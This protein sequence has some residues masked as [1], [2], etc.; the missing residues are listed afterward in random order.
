MINK[1]YEKLKNI[2]KNNYKYIIVLLLIITIFYVKFP[3]YVY[4]GGGTIDLNKRITMNDANSYNG[5]LNM[6]Y[7]SILNGTLFFGALSYIVPDWDVVAKSEVSYEGE[8]SKI[9]EKRDKIYFEEA[10]SN[11]TILAY[12]KAG[13]EYKINDTHNIATYIY[14]EAKTNLKL[15]DEIE[16][17]N[18]KEFTTLLDFKKDIESYNYGDKLSL[19]TNNGNRY[20]DVLNIDDNKKIGVS[21]ITTYDVETKNNLKIISK[22]NEYGS[23]GGLM[24][25]LAIYNKLIKEDITKGLNIVGTGTIDTDGNVGE[26]AGVKYKLMGANDIDADVFLVPH[27]NYKEA[28]EFIKKKDYNIKL[29]EVNSFDEAIQA[30]KEL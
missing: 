26:I 14:E 25:S 15:F 11:A 2:I 18:D 24:L 20:A 5:K 9:S 8:N 7:V 23:S 13:F 16:S 28:L 3:F 30:L 22:N 27:D 19:G 12:K 1:I 29:I 10:V 17:V 21:I 6:A 4:A